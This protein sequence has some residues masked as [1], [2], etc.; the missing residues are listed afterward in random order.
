MYVKILIELG[1]CD[2]QSGVLYNLAI[3]VVVRK[4]L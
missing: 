4:S 2:V 3:T 1:G